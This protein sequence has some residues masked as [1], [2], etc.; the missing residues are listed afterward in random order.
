MKYHFKIKKEKTG[1]SASCIELNGCRT[2]ANTLEELQENMREALDAYLDEPATSKE[3]LPIPN[4]KIKGRNIKGVEC[5]V[6]IAF[7]LLVRQARL[8]HN[9][10][11]RNVAK[12]L[13][14]KNVFAYQKLENTK[15]A[16][17]TL[18]TI[19][20]IKDVFPRLNLKIVF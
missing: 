17:P 13:G 2:Q 10:T 7:A 9:L 16:N 15:T 18:T 4:E 20:K 3:I 14:Y 6:C 1:Y 12:K 5:D 11:Q 19:K 8:K